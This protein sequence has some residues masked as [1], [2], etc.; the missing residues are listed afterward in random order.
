MFNNNNKSTPLKR[1]KL[2][3]KPN[4]L[5]DEEFMSPVKRRAKMS[6]NTCEEFFRQSGPTTTSFSTNKFLFQ[7][8]PI[9]ESFIS[10]LKQQW[11]GFLSSPSHSSDDVNKVWLK[12]PSPARRLKQSVICKNI[13]NL[14]LMSPEKESDE[15]EEEFHEDNEN[16][17]GDDDEE[18]EEKLKEEDTIKKYPTKRRTTTKK[19]NG[20]NFVKLNMRHR[21][22]APS[23]KFGIKK[24]W[25]KKFKN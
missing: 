23:S 20:G 1:K 9:D 18:V 25:R 7:R 24:K 17:E 19:Q 4:E 5:K 14:L 10:P 21:R 6:T 11:K 2:A 16:K 8:P 22:F 15:E 12:T 3:L 13:G